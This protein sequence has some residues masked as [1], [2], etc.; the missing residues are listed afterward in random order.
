M[1]NQPAQGRV[2][3]LLI[4]RLQPELWLTPVLGYVTCKTWSLHQR[5]NHYTW[6]TDRK[7]H[8]TWIGYRWT[9]KKA[10]RSFLSG[11]SER[12]KNKSSRA[13]MFTRIAV[14]HVLC[15]FPLQFS[16]IHR[17]SYLVIHLWLNKF[18]KRCGWESEG[19]IS[20]LPVSKTV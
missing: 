2:V 16:T 15:V 9:G 4:Y 8:I 10:L 11:R 12:S 5:R 17:Y 13:L 20:T 7:T 14:S 3:C 6:S 19:V 1:K 18:I